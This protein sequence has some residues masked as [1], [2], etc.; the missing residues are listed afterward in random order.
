[1]KTEIKIY[2]CFSAHTVNLL[3]TADIGEVNGWNK[4]NRPPFKKAA[5]KAQ[6]L[7]N[8]QNRSSHT[9]NQIKTAVGKKLKTPCLT[10]QGFTQI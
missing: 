6:G 1:M 9:A 3:A 7:W 10:R 4:G 5:A 8:L 2:I